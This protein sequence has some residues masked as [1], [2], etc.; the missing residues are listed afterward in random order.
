[1]TILALGSEWMVHGAPAAPGSRRTP[2]PGGG[3]RLSVLSR[4]SSVHWPSTVAWHPEQVTLGVASFE[5][6]PRHAA[7]LLER[8]LRAQ[9]EISSDVKILIL[10]SQQVGRGYQVLYVTVALDEWQQMLAWAASQQHICRLT[11]AVALAFQRVQAER[12]VVLQVGKHFHFL[13]RHDGQLVHL[14]ALAVEDTVADLEAVATMLGAQ[15][16]E[17]MAGRGF[18]RFSVAWVPA[19]FRGTQRDLDGLASAFAAATEAEVEL[20]SAPLGTLET[21][22]AEVHSG[23]LG[24]A[25][26]ARPKDLLNQGEDKLQVL[27]REYLPYGA[28]VAVVASLGLAYVGYGWM[29]DASALRQRTQQMEV[30]EASVRQSIAVIARDTAIERP[31]VNRQ[32]ELLHMLRKVQGDHDPVHLLNA[33]KE[34]AQGGI[35][36]LSVNSVRPTTDNAG[37]TEDAPTVVVDGTLPENAINSDRDTR[38]LSTLV[39]TLRMQGYLAKPIDIRSAAAG[40]DSSTRLFS[41]RVTR[42]APTEQR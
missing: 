23:L 21:T 41:Y 17:E 10:E 30:E 6:D 9:G 12:A 1:M 16:R 42:I 20:V 34:G 18:S 35:R 36:I 27:A 32:V 37:T 4:Y 39:Q 2:G 19:A 38:L 28:V 14:Q 29:A 5:G 26:N 25:R 24:L 3:D 31:S 40:Q 15:V 13:A 7:T 22:G 8:K 33:L 11:L